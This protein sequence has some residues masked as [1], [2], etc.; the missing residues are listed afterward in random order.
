MN[1]EDLIP[2]SL[3]FAIALVITI[4]FY[5]RFKGRAE[6][7]QTVRTVI[8]KGLQLTP[9]FLEKL[10]DR[11]NVQPKHWDLRLGVLAVALGIGIAAF[12]LV[13]GE[14]D[15]IRPLLAVGNVPVLIGLALIG[16]WKFM[17]RD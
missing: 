17:P 12:G 10:A 13:L 11:P 8:E 1:S 16:L 9:E 4:Y 3:F 6:Y 14:R 7:Q 15:A 5:F 2:I